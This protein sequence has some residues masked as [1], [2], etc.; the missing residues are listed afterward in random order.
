M[1]SW[2]DRGTKRHLPTGQETVPTPLAGSD[3]SLHDRA[4]VE[5]KGRHR[6]LRDRSFIPF[7]SPF[8]RVTDQLLRVIV[9]SGIKIRSFRSIPQ[10][11]LAIRWNAPGL[12]R[13][14]LRRE[15]AGR[16][17]QRM[18]VL[19]GSDTSWAG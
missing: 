3:V 17:Q 13:G 2:A 19:E 1:A 10:S 8:G 12:E 18:V 5:E 9:N 4:G 14:S 11:P 16:G 15:S 7:V 6:V